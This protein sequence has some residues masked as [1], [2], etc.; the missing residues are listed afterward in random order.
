MTATTQTATTD[1]LA[2]YADVVR[3]AVLIRK[4]EQRLLEL[5]KQGKLF[6]TIHTCIGQE[7]VGVAVARALEPQDNIFSNHRCHGHFLAYRQNL[8]G[9]IG[10]VMGKSV[11]VCGGRGGSQHLHQDRF[12]S[13]GVQGSIVPVSAGLAYG[14]KALGTNGVTVVFVGDGTL[15]EGVL[16]EAMNIASKWEL[17]LLLVCENNLYAQSTHQSQTLAGSIRGRAEAFGIETAYSDTWHW[18]ELMQSMAES[19]RRV[20]ST[21]KPLFHQ[22][23]TYRLMAHSKGDDNRPEQEV[24]P[25]WERDPLARLEE[26]F[27]SDARYRDIC[28][29]AEQLIDEAVAVCEAAP[30]T[31]D[32]LLCAAPAA[33]SKWSERSFSKERVVDSVRRGLEEGLAEH[34]RVVANRRRH[35]VAVW[36]GVQGDAGTERALPRAG[37]AIR[38]SA[39]AQS[40]ASPTAWRW[41]DCSRWRSS[42]SATSWRWPPTSGSTAPPSFTGCTTA[43]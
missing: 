38:R 11:G 29:E 21:G 9:L 32:S 42:C 43:R 18:P 12:Y 13:N 16:Y 8:V 1:L 36:R 17:P 5:F 6:G 35:R 28:K 15:G 14:Q 19:V 34:D 39:K 26:Q 20:R 37:C 22:V 24:A 4:T 31:A 33:H 25:Y 27:A 10:E 2:Q 40:P 30:F 41:P 23:D 3:L 7:F